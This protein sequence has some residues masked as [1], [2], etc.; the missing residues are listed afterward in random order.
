MGLKDVQANGE[1]FMFFFFENS[2]SCSKVLEEG[3]W[4]IGSQLLILK[5]WKRMLRLTKEQVSQIPIWVKLFNVPME[6]W[7]DEGLSRIASKIGVPLFMDY[8]TSSGNRISFARV[9][10]LVQMHKETDHQPDDKWTL[11]K[12]KGKNKISESDETVCS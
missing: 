5:K 8:L 6:Y 7:D 4:Y 10:K 12:A 1:G 3:P 2:N 9:E 11:V